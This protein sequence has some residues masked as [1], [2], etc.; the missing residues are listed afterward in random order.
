VA[1]AA[2]GVRASRDHQRNADRSRRAVA[3]LGRLVTVVDRA[4]DLAHLDR[5]VAAVSDRL[6]REN[7]DWFDVMS[8]RD[9]ELLV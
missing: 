7:A 5:A 8:Y 2:A 6:M 1:A 9:P 3:D 4:T